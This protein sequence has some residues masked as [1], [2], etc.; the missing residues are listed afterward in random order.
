MVVLHERLRDADFG[1]TER[2]VRLQEEAAFVAKHGWANQ[3]EPFEIEI[4]DLH[5]ARFFPVKRFLPARAACSARTDSCRTF[6]RADRA[7]LRRC[8]PC[9]T[10]SLR[11]TRWRCLGAVRAWPRSDRRRVDFLVC[12]YRATPG[13]APRSRASP[14]RRRCRRCS[15]P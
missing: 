6:A 1:I 13:R 15:R 12:P 10:R 4:G 2:V 5:G 8:N 11:G 3:L 9:D 7:A 14:D